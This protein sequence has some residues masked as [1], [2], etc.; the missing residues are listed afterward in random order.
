[1]VEGWPIDMTHSYEMM[2]LRKENVKVEIL[3]QTKVQ[4]CKWYHSWKLAPIKDIDK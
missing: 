4:D 3:I 2:C 1:M